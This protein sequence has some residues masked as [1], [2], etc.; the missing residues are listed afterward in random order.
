M[1]NRPT[2]PRYSALE[3]ALNHLAR[4]AFSEAELAVKLRQAEYPRGEIAS[5]LAECRRLGYLNDQ[6][7]A[8]DYA[9]YLAERGNGDRKIRQEL[10]A[11]GVVEFADEAIQALETGET[12]RAAAAGAYKLRLLTD[13]ADP[14]KKRDKLL[15][16]LAGR[17]F[18]PDAVYGAADLLLRGGNA[19]GGSGPTGDEA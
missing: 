7:Y 5:A 17:G 12:E 10:R 3:R 2:R 6:Q 9:V 8:R 16:F 1:K 14:R 18:S 11:R 19:D 4:R 15:R 13:E